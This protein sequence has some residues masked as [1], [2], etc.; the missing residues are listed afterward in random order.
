MTAQWLH[1]LQRHGLEGLPGIALKV[2]T[3]ENISEHYLAKMGLSEDTDTGK[4]EFEMTGLARKS[5]SRTVWDILRHAHYGDKASERLYLEYVRVMTGDKFLTYSHSLKELRQELE[6][7]SAE[8]AEQSSGMVDWLPITA[9]WWSLIWQMKLVSKVIEIAALSRDA[10]DVQEF[11]IDQ[12]EQALAG[13]KLN[14]EQLE[15][16]EEM[17]AAL[18][19]KPLT[20]LSRQSEYDPVI[21][22]F[23]MSNDAFQMPLLTG[24]NQS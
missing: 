18:R 20:D 2:S 15:F 4:L 8:E 23:E 17:Y 19:R 24:G 21:S 5:N 7:I 9:G 6:E 1:Q 3:H 14:A 11:I 10:G 13:R 22:G 16:K 12:Y